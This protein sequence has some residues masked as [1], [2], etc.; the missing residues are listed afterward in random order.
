MERSTLNEH[1]SYCEIVT[2]ISFPQEN[3]ALFSEGGEE[4]EHIFYCDI[5]TYILFPQEDGAWFSEGGEEVAHLKGLRF[6]ASRPLP[7]D[8]PVHWHGSCLETGHNVLTGS[9]IAFRKQGLLVY[10]FF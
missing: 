7:C 3:G 8:V 10:P 2:H 5:V 9:C 4:D 1:I 6:A